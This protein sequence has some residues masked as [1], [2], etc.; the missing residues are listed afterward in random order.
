M[1]FKYGQEEMEYLSS[2]C[3]KMAQVIEKAG[4]IKRE[5]MPELFPSLIQKIIGQQIST[6]AQITIT[7]RM[8]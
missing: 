3:E 4:F 2:R 6:A 7:K 8:N 5:T 1:Y